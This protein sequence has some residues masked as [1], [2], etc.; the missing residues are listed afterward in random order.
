MVSGT[1]VQRLLFV[2]KEKAE[3]QEAVD[4]S[5]GAQLAGWESSLLWASVWSGNTSALW[6]SV[7]GG[8]SGAALLLLQHGPSDAKMA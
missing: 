6:P 7:P 3:K 8:H 1:V 5:G 4:R 2:L